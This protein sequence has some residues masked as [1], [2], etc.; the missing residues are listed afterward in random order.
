MKAKTSKPPTFEEHVM[1]VGPRNRFSKTQSAGTLKITVPTLEKRYC[2]TDPPLVRFVNVPGEGLRTTTHELL[3]GHLKWC[4][5]Q[6]VASKQI[7]RERA[8][9]RARDADEIKSR[10]V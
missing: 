6:E 5:L 9:A 7:A 1:R 8:A 4:A 2:H 10:I 3:A